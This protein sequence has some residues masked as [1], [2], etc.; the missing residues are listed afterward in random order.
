MTG[1]I[2]K[3]RKVLK[4]FSETGVSRVAKHESSWSEVL[5]RDYYFG[6]FSIVINVSAFSKKPPTNA[7]NQNICVSDWEKVIGLLRFTTFSFI[8]THSFGQHSLHNA[9]QQELRCCLPNSRTSNC[10]DHFT[11]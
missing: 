1:T 11:K 5:V 10:P 3:K 8:S 2:R 9:K 6:I 7:Q 4:I